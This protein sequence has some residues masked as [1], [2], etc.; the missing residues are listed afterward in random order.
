MQIEIEIVDAFVDI[1]A[2][3]EGATLLDELY[4]IERTATIADRRRTVGRRKVVQRDRNEHGVASLHCDRDR[5]ARETANV[6]ID[7]RA[8]K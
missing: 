4:E 7:G 6:P 3:E 1:S 8:A 5:I 2:S